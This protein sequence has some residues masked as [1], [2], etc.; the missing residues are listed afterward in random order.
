MNPQLLAA[1]FGILGTNFLAP[2][3]NQDP[4]ARML[5]LAGQIANPGR[6][7]SYTGQLYNQFLQSPAFHAA[8]RGVTAGSNAAQ[9]GIISSLANRGLLGTGIGALSQGAARSFS[10]NA[11]SQLHTGAWNQA[12]TAALDLI[13][14]Q[15]G[16]AGGLP[17]GRNVGADVFG[18]SLNS[19]PGLIALLS[20]GGA[21]RMPLD[22]WYPGAPK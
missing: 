18:A 5:G 19:L 16:G 11:L 2:A 8:L 12:N 7:A 4:A 1:L 14:A 20:G 13:R 6:L 21:G 9:Q 22:T 15:L 10:G 3:F 17:V